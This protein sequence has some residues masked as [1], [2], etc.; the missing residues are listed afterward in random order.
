[1][2]KQFSYNLER[3]CRQ[4]TSEIRQHV[5]SSLI[6]IYTVH[7]VSCIVI[8]KERVKYGGIHHQETSP[9]SYSL[10]SHLPLPLQGLSFPPLHSWQV[11]PYLFGGQHT[12][13]LENNLNSFPNNKF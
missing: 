4:H 6:L 5:L 8:G 1:M 12:E 2:K 7:K 10:T 9:I 13:M 11:G 3:K